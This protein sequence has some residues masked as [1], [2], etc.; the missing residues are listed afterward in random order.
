M[1][2]SISHIVAFTLLISAAI[3]DYLDPGSGDSADQSD[4]IVLPSLEEIAIKYDENTTTTVRPT[5]ESPGTT[6]LVA[7]TTTS[8]TLIAK[9]LSP[10]TLTKDPLHALKKQRQRLLQQQQ[11]KHQQ[12]ARR[13]SRKRRLNQRRRGQR[14]PG[15]GGKARQ[16]VNS[17]RGPQKM[18]RDHLN[19][20]KKGQ[21]L[22]LSK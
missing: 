4:L 22:I 17:T 9:R 21:S 18:A 7:E 16:R 5:I 11:R 14:K 6:K 12:Q 13:R 10:S 8:R 19:N 15:H 20:Q 3:C 2:M 1:M